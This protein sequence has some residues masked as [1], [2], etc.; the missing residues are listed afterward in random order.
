MSPTPSSSTETPPRAQTTPAGD[1][2]TLLPGEPRTAGAPHR[3]G[4][5]APSGGEGT[6][7]RRARRTSLADRCAHHP[8]RTLAGALLALLGAVFLLLPGITTTEQQDILVG[9]SARAEA[10]RDAADFD[11]PLTENVL[12]G[13][14]T[15]TLDA[16]T[17]T[18]LGDEARA[19]YTGVTGVAGVGEPVLSPDRRVLLVPVALTTEDEEKAAGAV[20]PV[21]EVTRTLAQRH[22]ELQVDQ[23]GPGSIDRE[24]GEAVDG[25][26]RRAEFI[27]LPVTLA[28]LLIAFGAVLA[29]GIPVLLGIAAVVAAMGLTALV[30]RSGVPVDESS[31]SLVMLVG[32]AVGVDYALFVLRRA[33]EERAAGASVAESVRRA[34]AT[35]GRAVIVSGVTVVVA[36]SGMLV[37]GG[38]YTSLAVGALIVVAVAMVVSATVLPALLALLGDR[39]DALRLP[40]TR[41]RNAHRGSVDSVWGRLAGRVTAHP[42]R[43]ALATSAVLVALA[44]PALGMRTALLGAEA[45]PES[46]STVAAYHRMTAAFPQ[47]GTTA[48]VIVKAPASASA[49]VDAALRAAYPAALATG[50]V[51]GAEPAITTSTDGGTTVLSLAVPYDVSDSRTGEAVGELRED[52][53]PG[54]RSALASVPGAQVHLGGA[55]ADVELTSWM[56]DRLPWVVGFVLLLTFLVML[57]SFGSPW[58]AAATVA[59]NML[60]VG[61]AYGV[62]TLVF[63]YGWAEDLLGFRSAGAIEAWL[64]LLMFVILFGLSM[65]YHVFVVS[66][67]REAWN[68]GAGPREAV[69]LGVARSAGVVTSAAVVMVAVFSIFVTMSILQMK[70]MGVGLATAVLLDA[71]LVRGVLLPATLTLLGRR[72]HTGPRWVPALHG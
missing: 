17:V 70:Q 40:G 5:P 7:G 64:P 42:L 53:V 28:V 49:Q 65:D 6:T 22:P 45:L 24:V 54:I 16:A 18:R 56:D 69:R 39:V 30:S 33:R 15:G 34:G 52:V 27:S 62:L 11:D 43:W 35:A 60:S 32:L 72:A 26:F 59:L 23:V 51:V 1:A 19:A 58:L 44:V 21:L 41:R 47:D 55:A 46:F 10:L 63:Q 61:A 67:V 14:R 38:L 8:W 9:D 68:S 4:A 36:M 50:D 48:D 66:R 20:P 37:A 13:P 31:P 29:A 57:V 71:T 12:L 25:D 3:D 2:L